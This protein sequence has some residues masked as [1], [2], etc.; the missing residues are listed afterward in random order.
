MLSQRA[1]FARTILVSVTL[2]M[3]ITAPAAQADDDEPQQIDSTE[4]PAYS[5][6]D[7]VEPDEPGAVDSADPDAPDQAQ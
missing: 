1:H 5:A 6:S 3:L 7:P 4:A 2:L